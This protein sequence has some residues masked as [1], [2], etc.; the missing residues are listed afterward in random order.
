ML[1]VLRTGRISV[2][3]VLLWLVV[4]LA[5]LSPAAELRTGVRAGADLVARLVFLPAR[6]WSAAMMLLDAAMVAHSWYAAGRS[7]R[8]RRAR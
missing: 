4:A 6:G 2:G 1:D 8:G 5:A 3:S 7:R